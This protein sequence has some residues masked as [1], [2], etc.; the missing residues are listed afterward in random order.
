[1]NNLLLCISFSD[2]YLNARKGAKG[3]MQ[4]SSAYETDQEFGRGKRKKIKSKNVLDSD[5]EEEEECTKKMKISIPAPPRFSKT[6]IPSNQENSINTAKRQHFNMEGVSSALQQ[7]KKD[8]KN[9]LSKSQ[10]AIYMESQKENILSKLNTLKK[11]E[12]ITNPKNMQLFSKVTC[13][14]CEKRN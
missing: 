12:Q 1:M 5:F 9:I 2:V 14:G 11:K 13:D 3:F 10:K 6:L 4:F 8:L 7:G